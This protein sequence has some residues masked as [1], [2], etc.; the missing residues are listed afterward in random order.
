MQ[1][2]NPIDNNR[3]LIS[4]FFYMLT[5]ALI[6]TSLVQLSWFEISGGFCVSHLSLY[7]FFT[8]GYSDPPKPKT[9]IFKNEFGQPAFNIDYGLFEECKY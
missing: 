3:N 9:Y 4:A 2:L 7:T 5:I 1:W 6:S 8:F